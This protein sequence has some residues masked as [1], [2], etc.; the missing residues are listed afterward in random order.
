MSKEMQSGGQTAGGTVF[1]QQQQQRLVVYAAVDDRFAGRVRYGP[2][3][4]NA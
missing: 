4:L 1:A 3:E 2:S